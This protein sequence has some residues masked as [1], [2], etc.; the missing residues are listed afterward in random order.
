MMDTDE[1]PPPKKK[2][3]K[4]SKDRTERMETSEDEINAAASSAAQFSVLDGLHEHYSQDSKERAY[5][6]HFDHLLYI[7]EKSKTYMNVSV[8]KS[9]KKK[10]GVEYK[11]R[12]ILL[13]LGFSSS[14]TRRY[15]TYLSHFSKR[16]EEK[17]FLKP[18]EYFLPTP[19][20]IYILTSFFK[21]YASKFTPLCLLYQGLRVNIINLTC[22]LA[23]PLFAVF[24]IIYTPVSRRKE[25][26]APIMLQ[27]T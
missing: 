2:K 27:R 22:P 19:E 3:K 17:C 1:P 9:L 18:P 4:K 26:L 12:G 10:Q 13:Y 6:V 21:Y 5:I 14:I 8:I 15:L 23:N 11:Q 24:S 16:A 25:N 20:Q 7:Q